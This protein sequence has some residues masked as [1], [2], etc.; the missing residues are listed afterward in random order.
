M[1]R[2]GIRDFVHADRAFRPK[3][4]GTAQYQVWFGGHARNMIRRPLTLLTELQKLLALR[5]AANA[6]PRWSGLGIVR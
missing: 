6:W 1:R 2:L 5:R 3:W 4:Q